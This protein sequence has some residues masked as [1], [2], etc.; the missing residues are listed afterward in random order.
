MWQE[1]KDWTEV[2]PSIAP[3]VT[4]LAA[5]AAALFAWWQ[6]RVN[7]YNQRET[8]AKNIFREYLKLTIEY[9]HFAL[10]NYRKHKGI[11][12]ERYKWFVANFLWGAEEI[13]SFAGDDNI[14]KHN[15]QIHADPH[16]DY[17]VGDSNFMAVDYFGYSRD[18]QTLVD[19]AINQEPRKPRGS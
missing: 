5:I 12:R 8:T 1:L 15:L 10:G 11:E 4:L 9:P 13:M 7:R 18:V 14:W 6:L 3:C 2:A 17:F 19:D 16:R